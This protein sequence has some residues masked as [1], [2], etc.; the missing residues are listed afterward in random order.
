[1]ESKV[2]HGLGMRLGTDSTAIS[3]YDVRLSIHLSTCV[4]ALLERTDKLSGRVAE[5]RTRS[6]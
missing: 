2:T 6:S 5:C 4:Q 3:L 1:M